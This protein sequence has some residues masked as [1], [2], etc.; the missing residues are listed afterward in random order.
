MPNFTPYQTPQFEPFAPAALTAERLYAIDPAACAMS[1]RRAMELAVKWMYG[2]DRQLKKPYRDDLSVLLATAEFR[3]LVDDKNLLRRLDFLRRLGNTAAHSGKKISRDQARL[4]L[5]NLF[6]FLDFIAC[7]YDAGYQPHDFDPALLPELEKAVI[8]DRKAL[9]A[10]GEP[11]AFYEATAEQAVQLTRIRQ[12][13]KP[14]YV[15]RPLELT[16]YETR[17][18]YIDAMLQ[19]AGWT[20][21]R[22]WVNEYPV[23]GMPN[24]SGRGRVDYVLLDDDGRPLA[25]VEAKRTCQDPAAGRQQAKLYADLLEKKFGR[26]PVIFLTNGFDTRIWNHPYYNER[27]VSGVYAKRDLQKEFNKLTLRASLENASPR[28]DIA[29]RYYQVEAV[30][31]V[32]HAFDGENRRK[33]LLV[34]ATGSGK[35]RTV[36]SLVEVLL[37][38]GWVKNLLFLADRTSLVTQAKRTFA[39]LLP[40]LSLA[41]LCEERENL[42]ARAVFSTYQTMMG[43]ID[44]AR[45]EDGGKLFTS[46]HFDL[47]IVDEAHRSIYK[48]YQAIFDYFDA[49]MVG[50]TAT[51][52]AEIDKNTYGIFDL[53]EGDPTYGYEFSQAVEDGYLADFRCLETTLKFPSMGII[54]DELS[55]EDREQYEN[56][57]ADEDGVLPERIDSAALNE[58]VFNEDTIRK[59]LD[60]LMTNGLRVDY[61]NKLG[62]TILFARNHRHAEKI[63]EI[64]NRDYPAYVGWAQVIDNR[65]QYVQSAIDQF[66][67]PAKPPRIAISVD[68]LDTGIDVPEVVNLVFFKRVM[69]RAKF[70]QMIGRGSRLCPGLLDGADKTHFYIFDFCGN[71]AFFRENPKGREAAV[72]RSLQERI[73]NLKAQMVLRLQGPE[74]GAEAPAA[75]RRE[76]AEGMAAQ[77]A[78][79]DRSGF[80]VRL[81]LREVERF[82]KAEAYA[83]LTYENTLQ[84]EELARLLPPTGDEASAVQ[85]D[86]LLYSIELSGLAGKPC[87]RARRELLRKARAMAEVSNIPAIDRKRTF[88]NQLLH[89]D[90][91]E[92]AGLPELER[93]REELRDLI[94]YVPQRERIFYTTDLA[95]EIL[96]AQWRASELESD[97]LADYKE[98]VS[99]YIREHQSEAVIHKLHTNQP[100]TAQDVARLEEI[101]WSEAGSR[102]D[103]LR[104]YRDKPLGELVREIVGLDM[105]AAK[106]AFARYLNDVNLDQ[107]QIYFVNQI[108]GYVVK[109]GMMKDLSVLQR[110][111]FT[112]QGTIVEIFA[113]LALWAGIR[114]VIRSINANIGVYP[115]Q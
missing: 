111:P 12:E 24:A 11:V 101:L 100:L 41:N 26:R 106:E 28:E 73:F 114:E 83:G 61:G 4:A 80:A 85:F 67:D 57:F 9:A 64:F 51:P 71:F 21:G 79:L 52:K 72:Q 47:V 110:P 32:C 18:L 94:R 58:W 54:Y 70:W 25:L 27:P 105:N 109:N 40:D 108:V 81:R 63:L 33:A 65:T 53:R 75:F 14:A 17:K 20:E 48:K 16:E 66:S 76:L 103:Y 38:R 34:M 82:S 62:K 22:D 104:E 107:R 19:G 99:Y 6:Y 102:E 10:A 87:A 77:I 55:E 2:C 56:T 37:R 113:D 86:A 50:L 91:V 45:D 92:A 29:G 93:I 84:L 42:T 15:P 115:S 1:C 69:S 88:L 49:H 78:A 97:D 89:T 60:T 31:A 98:R 44:D 43:C 74:H 95:D 90:Y 8:V 39:N 59:A 46:G 13:R 3:D 96:S 35:T 30:K 23:E 68:M 7:C 36:I 5:E 112:D